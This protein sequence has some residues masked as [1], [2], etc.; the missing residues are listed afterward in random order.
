[1]HV[2][3]SAW[4]SGSRL[5]ELAHA[6]NN[7]RAGKSTTAFGTTIRIPHARVMAYRKYR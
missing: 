3:P 2:E 4:E 7:A 5:G 1:V 6:A